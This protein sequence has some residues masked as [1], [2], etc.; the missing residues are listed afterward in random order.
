MKKIYEPIIITGLLLCFCSMAQA[1][2][3]SDSNIAKLAAILSVSTEKAQQ[4][5]AAYNYRHLEISKLMKDKSISPKDKQKQ[6]KQ[7]LAERRQKL[8]AVVSPA[9]KEALSNSDTAL[10]AHLQAKA[11]A[12]KQ[13]HQQQLNRMPHTQT[14]SL[15]S[16]SVK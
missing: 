13:R 16:S 5:Q 3:T 1:Q 8:N 10:T 12:V 15:P 2:T 11:A 14:N 7:L 4:I 6:L 9:E